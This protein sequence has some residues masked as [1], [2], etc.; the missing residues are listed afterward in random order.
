M[1]FVTCGCDNNPPPEKKDTQTD[2]KKTD[3]K[4]DSSE[5]K[6]EEEKNSSNKNDLK[7]PLVKTLNIKIYY[8]DK[9]GLKL[10][11][12]NHEIKIKND[13]EKYFAAVRALLDKPEN[14]DLTSIFP[15]HTKINA[16]T[17]KGDTAFV[18]FSDTIIH[19][20]VGGSTGEELLVNS[21]VQTLTEFPEVKQVRFLVDG[22]EVETLV[23]HMDL[24][25]PIR[26][27]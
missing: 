6:S 24:S 2:V 11:A 18:D 1:L 4:K 14:K 25:T 17:V 16:V 26:R 10:V 13:N 27:N 20:F 15:S 22:K 7:N 19:N 21:V 9:S 23:G 3:T 8:P 12:V 5:K